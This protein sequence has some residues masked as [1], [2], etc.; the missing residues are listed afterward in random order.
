MKLPVTDTLSLLRIRNDKQ[1]G[2][3][4]NIMCIIA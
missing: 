4:N 3:Y 1:E 2:Y